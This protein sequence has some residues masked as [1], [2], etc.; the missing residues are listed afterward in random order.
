M[1]VNGHGFESHSGLNFFQALISQLHKLCTTAMI[2]HVFISFSAVQIYDLSYI[3]LH[4][5]SSTGYITNSQRDQLSVGLIAQLV[6][7][8]TGIA[9]VMGSNPV[10]A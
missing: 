9:E 1:A 3:H 2:N 6:E 7:H 4:S 10:Q 5:S 8:F